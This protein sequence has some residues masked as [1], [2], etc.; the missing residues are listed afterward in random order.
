MEDRLGVAL[1]KPGDPVIVR[2]R[3]SAYAGDESGWNRG[4]IVYRP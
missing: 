1:I 3:S 4:Y 2:M